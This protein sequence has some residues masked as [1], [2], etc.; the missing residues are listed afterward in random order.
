MTSPCIAGAIAQLDN[1]LP[2]RGRRLSAQN[3]LHRYLRCIYNMLR[4]T[5]PS[6]CGA[7]PHVG[8]AGAHLGGKMHQNHQ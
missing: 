7:K 6:V 4:L 8:S 5:S 1:M 2:S 3:P